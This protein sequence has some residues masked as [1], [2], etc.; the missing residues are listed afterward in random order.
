[1]AARVKMAV[2]VAKANME[3]AAMAGKEGTAFSAAAK[4]VT[5]VMQSKTGY[6][7]LPC[8]N[9][10]GGKSDGFGRCREFH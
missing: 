3:K 5:E 4:V 6:K 10:P 7:N 2:K 1:M 8:M 9:F